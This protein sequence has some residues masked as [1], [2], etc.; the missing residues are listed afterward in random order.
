MLT[1]TLASENRSAPQNKGSR[2]DPIFWRKPTSSVLIVGAGSLGYFT[3]LQI[4]GEGS[5][6]SVHG[7]LTWPGEGPHKDLNAPVLGEAGDL[8]RL[9][10]EQAFNE[11]YIAGDML[12][13]GEE[14]KKAARACELYGIPFALPAEPFRFDRARPRDPEALQD[15]YLHFVVVRMGPFQKAV[16]RLFDIVASAGALTLLSPLLLVVAALIKLTSAGPVFFKQKR[17]GL[18]GREFYMLKFRSMVK[19]AEELKASL[20]ALNEQEGP[21]FKI[22]NDPRVT[23]VG[24]IIRRFSIDELP[25]LINVFF[26]DMSIVGPRPTPPNEVSQYEPWQRRRHS[27]RPGITCVWQVS[28]RNDVQFEQWMYLDLQYIDHWSLKEDIKIILKTIPAV[29]SGKGAS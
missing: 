2:P 4:A 15:G 23:P 18:Y 16:K 9:L 3:G 22:R 5:R 27:V 29:L 25:Q 21:T 10:G 1:L 6:R 19:N 13:R 28:G 17:I 26:G 14:M 24:R 7:Y 12:R 8:E 20:M 11:V